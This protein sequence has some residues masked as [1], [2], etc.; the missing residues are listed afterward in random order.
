MTRKI[1]LLLLSIALASCGKSSAPEG[2][3]TASADAPAG[4]NAVAA[5]AAGSGDVCSLIGDPDTLF[6]Q[7]VTATANSTPNIGKSC[8]WKNAEG[9]LCGLVMPFGA[10]WNPVPDLKRNYDA[11]ATSMNA[12]GEVNPVAGIGEEAVAVDGK[13]MGAQMAIRTSNAIANI[14]AGCGGSG[15]ANLEMAEKIARAIAPRL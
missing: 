4:A 3:P 10:A 5:D 2:A 12:F 15:P 1:P 13:I 9:R 7:P 14:G 11:M 6:G 8:E